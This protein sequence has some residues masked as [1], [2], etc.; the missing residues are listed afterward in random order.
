MAVPS[1]AATAAAAA[2]VDL[3]PVPPPLWLCRLEVGR[4]TTSVD[5]LQAA[6]ACGSLTC[7]A[8]TDGGWKNDDDEDA[9]SHPF[10]PAVCEAVG[11]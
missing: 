2:A 5:V 6:A 8:L 3:L 1:A 11:R 10:M 7:L 4:D 9:D